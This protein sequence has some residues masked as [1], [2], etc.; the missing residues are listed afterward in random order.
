MIRRPPRSTLFPYTTLFRSDNAG[1]NQDLI[2]AFFVLK[3]ENNPIMLDNQGGDNVWRSINNANYDLDFQDNL[4]GLYGFD[5]KITTGAG[6][7]EIVQNWTFA[8]SLSGTEYTTNWQLPQ[9]MFDIMNR[10]E[11]R[12]VGKECRSR[13]SPYH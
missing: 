6:A 9:S 11:E 1:N 4:S 10:S 13:W 2:D 3:D 7:I 8:Q 5:I 12:R